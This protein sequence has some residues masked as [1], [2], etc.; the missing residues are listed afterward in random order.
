MLTGRMGD[1]ALPPPVDGGDDKIANFCI[2]DRNLPQV[3]AMSASPR[4]FLGGLDSTWTS[5]LLPCV[6][7]SRTAVIRSRGKLVPG[8]RI[9]V[10]GAAGAVTVT[11]T[12]DS[13]GEDG[14]NEIVVRDTNLEGEEGDW[15]EPID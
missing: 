1:D 13:M 3:A 6:L 2:A 7:L 8:D 10:H 5:G 9:R 4:D 14:W 15:L 11:A 12:E